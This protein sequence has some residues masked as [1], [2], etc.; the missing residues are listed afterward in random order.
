LNDTKSHNTQD[1]K[2]LE[3]KVVNPWKGESRG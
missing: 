1:V 3:V 2:V